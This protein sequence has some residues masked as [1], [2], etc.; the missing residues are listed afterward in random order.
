MSQVPRILIAAGGTGGHLFPAREI[1]DALRQIRP[2]TVIEFIGTGRAIETQVLASSNYTIR[3]TTAQKISKQG[4]LGVIKFILALPQMFRESF[5]IF[6]EFKPDLVLGV[7]GYVTVVPITAATIARIPTW[8]HEAEKKAGI[9]NSLLSWYASKIS[10]A[11]ED[12]KIHR[13]KRIVFTGHPLRKALRNFVDERA[14]V[15]EPVRLLVVGGSQGARG[16]DDVC[17]KL[18]PQIAKLGIEVWHQCRE[19]ARFEIERG[20]RDAQVTAKVQSFIDPMTAAYAWADIILGRAGAGTV[21]ELTFIGKPCILVPYPHA[22]GNH[23]RENAMTLVES[24]KAFI[25]EEGDNFAERLGERLAAI[26]KPSQFNSMREREGV[27]RIP[28]AA[29]RIAQGC[30]DLIGARDTK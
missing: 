1:A 20:Y 7:G 11:Y 13:S 21:L 26:F 19:E 22:E 18:A 27:K 3:Q 25:V 9:A 17:L 12:A 28:D 24:G 10:I 6:K 16:I 23:Q 2:E 4:I 29:Q 15:K 14:E 8:I 30:F 5:E